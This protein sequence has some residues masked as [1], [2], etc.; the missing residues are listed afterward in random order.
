MHRFGDFSGCRFDG[1]VVRGFDFTGCDLTGAT[2]LRAQIEH[3]KFDCTRLDARALQKAADYAAYLKADVARDPAERHRVIPSRLRDLAIFR[4]APFAPEMVVIAAGEFM[5]GCDLGDE[6]LAEDDKAWDKEIV[7]GQGKRLMRIPR[8][9]AIGRYPV[10]FQEYDVFCEAEKRE[11]AEDEG[12]GRERRPVININWNDAQAFVAWLNV[13][14]GG[15]AYRLPSET[16]WEYACRAGTSTRR[17]WGEIRGMRGRR[18]A[19]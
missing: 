6:K 18:T 19:P 1:D 2:F 16:E 14:L 3:A 17:W 7:P 5:M 15:A 10:T 9:F 13:R 4:E 12:W 11:K 8:C